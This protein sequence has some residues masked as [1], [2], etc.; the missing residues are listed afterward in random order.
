MKRKVDE[1]GSSMAPFQRER[2]AWQWE[3]GLNEEE[4]EEKEDELTGRG[5]G[6]G[7]GRRGGPIVGRE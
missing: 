3:R 6:A 2:A 5:R 1:V 7:D 4:V